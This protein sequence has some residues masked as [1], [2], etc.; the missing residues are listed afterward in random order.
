MKIGAH[1]SIAGGMPRAV[2]R[3][4]ADGC[5]SLQ[6]FNK[7]SSQW[8]AKELSREEC[9]EFRGAIDAAKLPVMS[10]ASYLVNLACPE[11]PMLQKG[12]AAFADELERCDRLGIPYLV[13]H[14]GSHKQ[15]GEEAGIERMAAALDSIY[16]SRPGLATDVLLENTAGMG[17]C[18]GHTFEQLAAI[19]ASAKHA[20]R[21]G[22]CFDTCHAFAA[23]YDMRTREGYDR[24]WADFDR[25][26]GLKHLKAFHLNDSKKDFHCRVDRHEWIGDGF[27]GKDTFRYLMND[28]RF[29]EIPG[30]VETPPLESGEM[31]FTLNLRRLRKMREDRRPPQ[32]SAAQFRRSRRS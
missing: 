1:E 15:T 9:A 5:E 25:V 27:I 22:I 29:A 30:V 32:V 14:P 13:V 2:E 10:H 28:A 7:S 11:P 21:L 3:A 8:K 12:I 31:S 17:A 24:T 4:V 19:R 23:G 6:V 16:A 26:I 20:R 18:L